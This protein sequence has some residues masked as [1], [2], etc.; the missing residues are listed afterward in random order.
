VVIGAEAIIGYQ[1]VV[2]VLRT[3]T[4]CLENHFLLNLPVT[5]K[6]NCAFSI[7]TG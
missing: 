5:P 2:A 4:C 7:C 3:P 6:L 1:L